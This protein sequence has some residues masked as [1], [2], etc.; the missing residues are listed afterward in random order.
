M[1]KLSTEIKDENQVIVL[2][3]LNVSEIVKNRKLPRA[4]SDLGG[5]QFRTLLEGKAEK[6]GRELR[7]IDRWQPTSQVYSCCGFRGGK[8]GLSAREWE[9]LN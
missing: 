4:I 6:C 8:L 9:Y 3:D 5:R 7:V 1:H 2:E